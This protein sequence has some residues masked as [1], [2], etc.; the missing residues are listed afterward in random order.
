[1]TC[2]DCGHGSKNQEISTM[3]H[4]VTIK[5]KST[6]QYTWICMFIDSHLYVSLVFSCALQSSRKTETKLQWKRKWNASMQQS[7]KPKNYT[8]QRRLICNFPFSIFYFRWVVFFFILFFSIS[9]NFIHWMS[10]FVVKY[11]VVLNWATFT[12]VYALKFMAI[13]YE[14]ELCAHAKSHIVWHSGKRI[15]SFL[16]VDDKNVVTVQCAVFNVRYCVYCTV[17]Y[18]SLVFS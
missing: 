14:C 11:Q 13:A 1:M 10:V 12:Y 2:I 4:V 3:H 18:R 8:T 15:R 7:V 9:H 16:H 17:L 5:M 6:A